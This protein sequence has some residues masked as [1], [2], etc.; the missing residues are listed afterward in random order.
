MGA[1]RRSGGRGARSPHPQRH[2][3]R[4]GARRSRVP[5][6]GLGDAGARRHAVGNAPHATLGLCRTRTRTP[7]TPSVAVLTVVDRYLRHVSI[8]RGLS[9]NT[10]AAYRRDLGA[11]TR[12]LAA[13][14]IESAGEVSA[15]HVA[16]FVSFMRTRP[17]HP[18]TA[19]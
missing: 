13:Q 4:R 19:S 5:R 16:G 18:L 17:E 3:E 9:R 7:M 6:P 10:V 12:W 11:Y 2:R 14:G 1:A 15:A 8:E